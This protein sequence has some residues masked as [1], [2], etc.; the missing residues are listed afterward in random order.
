MVAVMVVVTLMEMVAVMVLVAV[1]AVMKVAQRRD[2]GQV[3]IVME[4]DQIVTSF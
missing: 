4:Y 2:A 3:Q 1:V